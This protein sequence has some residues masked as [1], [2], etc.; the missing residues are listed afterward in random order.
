MDFV[1]QLKSSVDIVK[2]IQGYGVKLKRTGSTGRYLGLCPFHTE[3]TPSFNVNAAMQRFKCFGC[4]LGGDALNFVM[5]IERISFFEALKLLAET[6]GIPMPKREY[7]DPDSKLRGALFEMHEIA[8]STFQ[9][10][11]KGSAGA[12]AR[13]YLAGRGVTPEQI[14]EFGLGVSDGSGQQLMR[15]FEGRFSGEMLDV[16]GLVLKRQDGSGYFDRFRGRLMF[17][18]HNESGKVI[19]FGGRAI[20]NI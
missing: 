12:E 19:G 3:K 14:E 2:T 6:N 10:N 1:E 16:S 4:Q 9:S 8:A 20:R 7:S 5:E 17:P 15:R 18:I 13:N 11:L